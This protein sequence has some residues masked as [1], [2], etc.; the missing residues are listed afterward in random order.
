LK[1]NIPVH[2]DSAIGGFVLPWIEKLG[3]IIPKFDFRCMGVTSI[4]ADVHKYGFAPK[5]SSVLVYRSSEY[6]KFQ[7]F[8]IA[9]WPAGLYA[10][11]TLLGTR[12]GGTLASAWAS[13]R[14]LG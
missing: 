8:V 12:N 14:A 6:R 9:N 7:F 1:H 5:G 10:S 4:S 3:Y 13:L 11:P 2:V